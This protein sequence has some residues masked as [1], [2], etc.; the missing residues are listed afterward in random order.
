MTLCSKC[1]LKP[2]LP[3]RK[4]CRRC[5]KGK[6]VKTGSVGIGKGDSSAFVEQPRKEAVKTG[7]AP[8]L[9]AFLP[10]VHRRPSGLPRWVKPYLVALAEYGGQAL[11]A[12]AA[13]V[14]LRE[15]VELRERNQ[16][17]DA[18]CQA[19][20]EWRADKLAHELPGSTRPVGSIVELKR[21]RPALYVEKQIVMTVPAPS[22]DLTE[23]AADLL[24]QIEERM[25][26]RELS[27]MKGEVVDVEAEPG[28]G[29]TDTPRTVPRNEAES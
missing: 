26:R 27:A 25:S 8:P 1:G 24:A 18:E 7:A 5:K 13:G 11:A 21:H 16:A 28:A 23:R 12:A 22:G 6:P 15:A 17:F 9:P 2:P 20:L 3:G 4:V 14:A 10:F 19:A 29:H